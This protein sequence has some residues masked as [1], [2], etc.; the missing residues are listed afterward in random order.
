MR[1][2]ATRSE[3]FLADYQARDLV[4][5]SEL[6]L[7]KAGNF[8]GLRSRL[9]SNVG[10]YVITYVP[11]NKTSELLNSVYRIPACHV[12]SFAV[13]SNTSPTAPYRSAGRPEAMFIMERLIDLAAQQHGFDRLELRRRNLIPPRAMPFK[14]ALGLTYDSG[15]FA[16]A[17]DKA[18]ALADWQGFPERRREAK[19]R[20]LLRGFGFANYIEVTSGFPMERSEITVFGKGTV[21]VVIGTT[22]SGQGHETSFAQCVADWLGVPFG[23]IRLIHGDTNVVKEGGGSHS[24]RSMRMAGIVMGKAADIIIERGRRIAGHLLEAARRRHRFRVGTVHHQGHRS[25]HRHLRRRTRG[26]GRVRQPAG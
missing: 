7:D 19:K 17:M 16:E 22:P 21:D 2:Q 9:I 24:A 14:T 12:E 5:D 26:G 3:G 18:L 8:L 15:E 23:Q 25:Q 11:L 4:A 13:V 20:G 1:W 6:A 10:A